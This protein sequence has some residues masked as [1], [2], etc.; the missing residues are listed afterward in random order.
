MVI[1]LAS[2]TDMHDKCPEAYRF[3]M[4][5]TTWR[6]FCCAV[7]LFADNDYSSISMR[8]I[9]SMVGIKAASIYN[10]F[11]SKEDLLNR[12]IDFAGY[13]GEFFNKP[14]E[15]LM[16]TIETCPPR[17][18][19]FNMHAYY[20]SEVQPIMS[21]LLLICYNEMR[22][23]ERADAVIRW[24]IMNRPR[25]YITAVLQRMVELGRIEP[26]DID[27]FAEIYVNNYYGAAM[28]M[29]SSHPVEDPL[30][31]RSYEM[32]FHLITPTQ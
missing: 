20:P 13:Y 10:H 4:S 30:W 17:E 24:L 28:R 14:L 27:A 32:L 5:G 9:A 26:M 21:R 23:N 18:F 31:V 2:A 8:D 1:Y 6:L 22:R 19:L 11:D 3:G 15:E 7:D 12:M 25:T 29:H 16:N